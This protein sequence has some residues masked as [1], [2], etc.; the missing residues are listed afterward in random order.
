MTVSLPESLKEIGDGAFSQ[1][2]GLT[3]IDLK[4]LKSLEKT[5]SPYTDW[6]RFRAQSK[7]S[8][9]VLIAQTAADHPGIRRWKQSEMKHLALQVT[10]MA[11]K[12]NTT[13]LTDEEK[14]KQ[15]LCLSEDEKA[16]FVNVYLPSTLK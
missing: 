1:R 10:A 7:R 2:E 14:K 11:L 8:G 3:E 15:S 5:L 13:Y 6:S 9:A 4:M 16:G 12:G